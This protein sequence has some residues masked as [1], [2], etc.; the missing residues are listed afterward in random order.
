MVHYSRNQIFWIAA[1]SSV[2]VVVIVVSAFVN[3]ARAKRIVLDENSIV[4]DTVSYARPDGVPDTVHIYR[5]PKKERFRF[6]LNSVTYDRLITYPQIANGRA[7]AILKY[8]A[9]LGGYYSVDQLS[10]IRIMNDTLVADLKEWAFV[11]PDSIKR[12]DV[13]T[14]KISAMKYHPYITYDCARRIDSA[15][16]VCQRRGHRFVPDSCRQFFSHDDWQRV[17]PYLK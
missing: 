11:E 4:Y 13:A 15:R 17:R 8:R 5:Q 7:N 2:A 12:I 10:D 16:W 1:L 3:P 14:A 9:R 6:E